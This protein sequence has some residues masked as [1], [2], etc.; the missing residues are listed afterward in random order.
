MM[1][2]EH[3]SLVVAIIAILWVIYAKLTT[4]PEVPPH[5]P[6][7]GVKE[8][9]FAKLRAR[10]DAFSNYINLLDDGYRKVSLAPI[11]QCPPFSASLAYS[12]N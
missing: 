10:V 7:V 11:S 8:G 2:F 3:L 5:L 12:S 9:C 6:W 1:V 4:P